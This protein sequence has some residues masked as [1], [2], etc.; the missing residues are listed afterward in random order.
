MRVLLTMAFFSGC[1]VVGMQNALNAGAGLIYPTSLRAN[2]VGY[3]LGI[4][5]LGSVTGRCSAA[6]SPSLVCR[7]QYFFMLPPSVPCFALICFLLLLSRLQR[8]RQPTELAVPTSRGGTT[9]MKKDRNAHDNA[10][11]AFCDPGVFRR[12]RAV[13]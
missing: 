1:V 3:A 10:G 8:V 7:R 13:R 9:E 5:R 4:G 2:G 12:P 6:C 11:R